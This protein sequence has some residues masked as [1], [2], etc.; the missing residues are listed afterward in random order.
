LGWKKNTINPKRR[1]VS[2]LQRS[3]W[4]MSHR[5]FVTNCQFRRA[6]NSSWMHSFYVFPSSGCTKTGGK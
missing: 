3:Q 1:R 4:R 6:S 5:V 2:W